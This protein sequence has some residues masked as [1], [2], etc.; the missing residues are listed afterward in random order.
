VRAAAESDI[1]LVSAVGHETDTTLIDFASDR[2]AP[3]PTAAAEMVVPVRQDLIARLARDAASLEAGLGRT[4][5][6]NRTRLGNAARALG[7]PQRLLEDRSQ[8]LDERGERLK[9]AIAAT[10]DARR[11]RTLELGAR[12]PDPKTQLERARGQLL[13]LGAGLD[14]N[15]KALAATTTRETARLAEILA[16][17]KAALA[18]D[19]DARAARVSSL[20]MLLDSVSYRSVLRRGFALVTDA[21]GK[22]LVSAA[23]AKPGLDVTLAFADG[24]VAAKIAGDGGELRKEKPTA[25]TKAQQGSLL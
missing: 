11:R 22:P 18:R 21:D 3:T 23:K 6:D 19:M 5:A 25:K 13:R 16:R 24:A 4:L 9:L 14:A 12:L 7:D 10:L 17:G 2:R 8:R 1:P 15:A 20:E